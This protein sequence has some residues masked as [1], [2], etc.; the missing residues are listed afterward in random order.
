MALESRCQGGEDR[1]KCHLGKYALSTL[2]RS[3]ETPPSPGPR[4]SL[5]PIMSPRWRIS[6]ES[7]T[8][9]QK[10]FLAS[11]EGQFGWEEHLY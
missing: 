7:P 5:L 6:N 11:W 4:H 10:L 3:S 9:T 2:G 1:G 8:G